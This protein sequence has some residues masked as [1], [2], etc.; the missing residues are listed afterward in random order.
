MSQ[1]KQREVMMSS[2]HIV[3][4]CKKS[5]T[6]KYD[7]NYCTILCKQG[8]C[9]G[10]FIL[11][12]I[13]NE[14]FPCS[15]C[16]G[17]IGVNNQCFLC[18]NHSEFPLCFGCLSDKDDLGDNAELAINMIRAQQTTTHAQN[19]INGL[20]ECFDGLNKVTDRWKDTAL[21]A[22]GTTEEELQ[23]ILRKEEQNKNNNKNSKEK[24]IISLLS[25]DDDE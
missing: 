3:F 10:T 11:V 4:D 13:L 23:D 25:D 6:G 8:D 14:S 7:S 18:P 22:W 24:I 5:I 17:Q 9:N 21:K 1:Q 16:D 20:Q 19:V 2:E 12:K 15:W